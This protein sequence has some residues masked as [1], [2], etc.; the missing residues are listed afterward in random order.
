[1]IR[2]NP[3]IARVDTYL[4]TLAFLLGFQLAVLVKASR[5]LADVDEHET[6]D[7]DDFAIAV[8]VVHEFPQAEPRRVFVNGP[9]DELVDARD[10][11]DVGE[12]LEHRDTP[13]SEHQ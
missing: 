7:V 5:A 13:S 12:D 2:F 1:M 11:P 8:K 6:A 4:W 10:T 9:A 3:G